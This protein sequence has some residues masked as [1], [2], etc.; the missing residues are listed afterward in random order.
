MTFHLGGGRHLVLAG[1]AQAPIWIGAGVA[2][3]TLLLLL[4]RYELKLVS[5]R[6]GLIL[7][8]TRLFVALALIAALFEP[9][10]ERRYRETIRGRVIL[11]VDYSESMSTT[12]PSPAASE[13]QTESLSTP[14]RTISRKDVARRLLEG[15]WTKR[16]AAEHEIDAIGFARDG[17]VGTPASLA[18][19]LKTTSKTLDPA[20][21]VTDWNV[22][23]DQALKGDDSAPVPGVVLLTDGRRN[24]PGDSIRGVER[25]RARGIA[26]YPVMIGSTVPPKDVAVASVKA[27]ESVFKGDTASVE[28]TLK[29]D[30]I[31]G[32]EVPV[33]LE[34]RGKTPLKQVVRGQ[35]DGFRPVA[36]FRVPMDSAGPRDL[37]I[38][39]GPLF[40][41]ARP[42]NDRRTVSVQVIDDKAKILLIDAEA[43]WEFQYLR[44]ALLRDPRVSVDAIVFHQ[45]KL[46]AA[47][48]AYK[49]SFPD[50]GKSADLADPLGVYDA[51]VVGDIEPAL[52]ST[53]SWARLDKYVA[54]RG[55]TLILS[56]GPRALSGGTLGLETV[57]KLLPVRDPK[58]ASLELSVVDPNHPNLPP[59]AAIMPAEGR[60][61][62]SWPMLQ[63][64]ADPDQNN[65]IWSSL[66]RLPWLLVGRAKPGA[67][68]LA[69]LLGTEPSGEGAAIV[70]QPYGLGKVLWMGVDSTWRWR[71]RIGDAYHHRF[72]GQTARWAVSGKLASGN[73]LVR[74]GPE[75]A[76]V[77]S[78]DD[79]RFEA[80]FAES[81]PGVGPDLLAVAR[82]YE[83]A[84]NKT[85]LTKA[86]GDPRAVVTLQPVLGRPRTFAA[87]AP[88]LPPGR[89][90]ARLETPQLADSLKRL[91]GE[92]TTEA[93]LEIVPASTSELVELAADRDSLERLA[94]A[95]GGRV[96]NVSEIDQL[97]PLLLSRSVV[98]VR[99]EET[100]LWDRPWALGLFF[101]ALTVEWVARKRAGLP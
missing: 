67:T 62:S 101:V 74:F 40:G 27:P 56:F 59:G 98:K 92:A 64:S 90:V 21:L 65:A 73:D 4:Y 9:I 86:Q 51:I 76:K 38:S 81:V 79:V 25:L 29:I 96:F 43:R 53:D 54:E 12:D 69:S 57:R 16:I 32:V 80:R 100:T 85:G 94:S 46:A 83:T 77:W 3:F 13:N 23:F 31:P 11:G 82:V 26:V 89:Y 63:L 14:P 61:T 7:L 93:T 30:G 52:L 91:G 45:P 99:T 50:P 37:R 28:V 34:S 60:S 5:R 68:V 24:A 47:E 22:V 2:T 70:A 41:D 49:D 10:A 1:G 48:F 15:E 71:Y 75:R 17:V 66:P 18:E 20:K 55:G 72:W 78:G 97:P 84:A 42:D 35:K 87:T 58:Q 39:V 95:S 36:T 6:T 19:S 33:I 88:A 8:V 44:N